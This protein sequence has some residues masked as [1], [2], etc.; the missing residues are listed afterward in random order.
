MSSYIDWKVN[1]NSSAT[2]LFTIATVLFVFGKDVMNQGNKKNNK[3]RALGW[4]D[5][6]L[7][8]S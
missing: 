1:L 5:I 2:I 4:L 3:H 6:F 7:F 8:I